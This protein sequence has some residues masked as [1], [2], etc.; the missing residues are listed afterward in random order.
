MLYVGKGADMVRWKLCEIQ[1][2][3][4]SVISWMFPK[5]G[6]P[7]IIQNW[8]ILVLKPMGSTFLRNHHI[9]QS[10][11]GRLHCRMA[12]GQYWIPTGGMVNTKWPIHLYQGISLLKSPDFVSKPWSKTVTSGFAKHPRGHPHVH[13][14]SKLRSTTRDPSDS[15]WSSHQRPPLRRRDPFS[16]LCDPFGPKTWHQWP[17]GWFEGRSERSSWRP[18][19]IKNTSLISSNFI[20][21]W[22]RSGIQLHAQKLQN[23]G[24]NI[25][26][27]QVCGLA[28]L[29]IAWILKCFSPF[30]CVWKSGI[31]KRR[32]FNRINDDKPTNHWVLRW[33]SRFSRLD[34]VVPW[35]AELGMRQHPLQD[36]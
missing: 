32:P 33:F 20:E 34:G 1:G 11:C 31:P 8:T 26:Y 27:S 2:A 7:Q 3:T 6:Y 35:P 12:T 5:M 13:R 16:H 30:G 36:L 23:W 24:Q 4:S 18:K 22:K 19:N 14:A 17:Q 15:A 21:L 28:V 9:S 25:V 10:M 29:E